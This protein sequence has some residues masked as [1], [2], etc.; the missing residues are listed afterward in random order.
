MR[1]NCGEATEVKD[2]RPI[3]NG[4]FVRRRRYCP[5]CKVKFTTYEMS[6]DEFTEFK[7]FMKIKRLLLK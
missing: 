2:S 4:I 1:H 5:R 7:K 3:K 6:A